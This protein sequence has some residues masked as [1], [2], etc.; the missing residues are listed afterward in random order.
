MSEELYSTRQPHSPIFTREEKV[1][2]FRVP[3]ERM[4]LRDL[5]FTL[6]LTVPITGDARHHLRSRPMW[7]MRARMMRSCRLARIGRSGSLNRSPEQRTAGAGRAR[8]RG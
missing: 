5:K 7:A 1:F 8:Q 6:E 3:V 2:A 4:V